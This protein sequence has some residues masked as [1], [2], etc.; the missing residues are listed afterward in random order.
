MPKWLK[1]IAEKIRDKTF[2]FLLVGIVGWL[3]GYIAFWPFL[4]S[5]KAVCPAIGLALLASCA[6]IVYKRENSS[7][8]W[9]RRRS[10][11]MDG[12]L[13]ALDSDERAILVEFRYANTVELA[14]DMPAV[15][16]LWAK[17]VLVPAVRNGQMRRGPDDK[18]HS[19]F[20]MMISHLAQ[21]SL[22]KQAEQ[23]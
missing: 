23:D 7:S 16:G 13:A 17:G 22:Q 2:D 20:P 9:T 21:E 10:R 4:G 3:S 15:A 1:W 5:A 11:A 12:I 19:V 14:V 18:V 8:A 6:L